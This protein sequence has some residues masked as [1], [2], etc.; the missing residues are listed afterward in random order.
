MVQREDAEEGKIKNTEF[1]R[2]FSK[3]DK[4]MISLVGEKAANLG[5]IYNNKFPVPNGFV[6]T[7]EAYE[8]FLFSSKI[9]EKINSLLNNLDTKNNELLISAS[10]KIKKLVVNSE[11][12]EE[13]K[14]E[15]IDSYQVLGS[16][17]IEIERGSAYDIL[18]NATEP[19]FVSVRSSLCFKS[20]RGSS[21]H[22]QDTYLNVK[23]NESLL[24]HVKSAFA[25][26]FNPDTLKRELEKG[27]ESGKI[28]IAVIV[29]KMVDSD[30]SG[31][32]HSNDSFVNIYSVWGLGEG[33]NIKNASSDKYVLSRDL[34]LL[35]KKIGEKKYF[36][37]RDSSGFLKT[38]NSSEERKNS[39]VLNNYELQRIGDLAEK[40]ESHFGKPQKIEFGID[41]SG[42]YILQADSLENFS[43]EES[44]GKLPHKEEK[45]VFQNEGPFSVEKVEKV[46]KT[47]LKLVLDSPYFIDEVKKSGL[48]KAGVVKIEKIIQKKGKHPFYFFESH[49]INEYENLVFNGIKPFSES[50]EEV[51]VRTSDFLTSEF[52]GLEGGERFSEE[53][54]LLGLHGI[55]FGL[56]YPD[57]LE[58]ELRAVK[59]IHEKTDVGILIPNI[60]C[61]DEIRKVK[62]LLKKIDFKKVKVG[63]IIET[64]AAVQLIKEF[65]QEGVDCI[66]L[67]TDRLLEHIL[68]IDRENKNVS[69]LFDELNSSFLYQVEYL[70]RVAKRNNVETNV[71]GSALLNDKVLKYLVKKGVEFISVEPLD[72]KKVSEKV[73]SFESE[74]F[75]GTDLE[76]R[77][78]ELEKV[79]DDYIEKNPV[80]GA[81]ENTNHLKKKDPLGIL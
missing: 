61:V 76:P 34:Q 69:G 8:N 2:W 23:G 43:D 17:K 21:M 72:A 36:V 29:E 1:V 27:L 53:N 77:K 56:K 37:M 33:M 6:I 12:P 67:N 32:V 55:R 52:L 60:I 73:Y 59:R 42:I 71:F 79:K 38:S 13:L 28:K 78:Y 9:S 25:S 44:A 15:I 20:H 35:E 51:Y 10:E 4:S 7:S 18:N 68:A 31:I 64:P 41:E 49:Y 40:I 70:M 80:A 75:H 58:A 5:E 14:E 3:I 45:K 62:S 47:K 22:E 81:E 46:T 50:F 48:K 57:I 39:Q 16:N 63:V 19:I 30:K 24:E 54:P 65:C 26:L 11:L 66:V 74:L